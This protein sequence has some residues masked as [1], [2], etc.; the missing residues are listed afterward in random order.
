M[1][2]HRNFDILPAAIQ[3]ANQFT[4]GIPGNTRGQERVAEYERVNKRLM[5]KKTRKALA[6]SV[7]PTRIAGLGGR[8]HRLKSET[9]TFWQ[10]P[11]PALL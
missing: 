3:R 1:W 9:L 10:T 4:F 8:T 2:G 5:G 6:P 7:Q 11:V